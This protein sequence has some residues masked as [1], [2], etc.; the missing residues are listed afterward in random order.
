MKIRI[1][2]A[3]QSLTGFIEALPANFATEGEV[4]YQGRN[5]LKRYQVQGVDLVVKSFKIPFWFN[6]VAYTFFRKS[7]ACRSYQYAFEIIKRGCLTP[8]PIAY[9]E[10]RVGG[11]LNRSY[12]VSIYEQGTETMR[13][14]MSGTVEGNEEVLAAFTRFTLS[15]HEKGIYHIDYSPGNILMTRNS[16]YSFSLVDINRLRF[17]ELS[18]DQRYRNLERLCVSMEVSSWIAREYA[19]LR[20][21]DSE[22]AERVVNGYSD[23]F[24]DRRIKA[25]VGKNLRKSSGFFFWPLLKYDTLRWLRLSWGC[26]FFYSKERELYFAYIETCDLRKVRFKDY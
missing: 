20:G 3:Y 18:D 19:S 24:F 2:P 14:Y 23:R 15:L 1:N 5:V 4:I 17:C 7:K 22:E 12:Y 9:L 13:K 8:A 11:L 16:G 26:E 21:T 10:E 6:R 25:L